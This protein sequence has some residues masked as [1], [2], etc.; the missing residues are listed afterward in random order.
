MTDG[1][2]QATSVVDVADDLDV[3]DNLPT[4]MV[5]YG[6]RHLPRWHCSNFEGPVTLV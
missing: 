4:Y 3:V 2:T 5:S 1:P 6:G